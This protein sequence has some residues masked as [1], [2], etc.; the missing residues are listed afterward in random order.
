MQCSE[1]DI[2]KYF[3]TDTRYET[4]SNVYRSEMRV[5][6]RKS[7]QTIKN[8]FGGEQRD[9]ELDAE[10]RTY[11]ELRADERVAAGTAPGVARRE[12][13]MEMGGME[14][15]KEEVREV[16]SGRWLEQFAQDLRF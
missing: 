4:I 16:R 12:A 8:W 2:K 3:P 10:L 9:R 6:W 13:L 5:M 11:A 14:Q 1:A 15:L 7:I